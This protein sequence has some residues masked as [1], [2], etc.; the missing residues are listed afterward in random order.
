MEEIDPQTNNQAIYTHHQ[1]FVSQIE[2]NQA[3]MYDDQ[4]YEQAV[5]LAGYQE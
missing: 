5:A 2:L 1:G 4:D 3:D